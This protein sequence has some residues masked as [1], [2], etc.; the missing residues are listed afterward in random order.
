MVIRIWEKDK[1]SPHI[2][3]FAYTEH[4]DTFRRKIE[5][6]NREKVIIKFD[7]SSF[8]YLGVT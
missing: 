3:K 1:S 5:K 4:S 2:S 6:E 8:S 7:L